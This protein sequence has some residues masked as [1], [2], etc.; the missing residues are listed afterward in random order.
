MQL[1]ILRAHVLWCIDGWK[2]FHT[3]ELKTHIYI[4]ICIY[5]YIYMYIAVETASMKVVIYRT[6]SMKVEYAPLKARY[7]GW[8]RSN[9]RGWHRSN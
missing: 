8:N 5:I 3:A 4:Y 6:V 1:Y 7:S 2:T 9:D